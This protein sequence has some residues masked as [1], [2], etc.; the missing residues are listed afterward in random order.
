[1]T[2]TCSLYLEYCDNC[3]RGSMLYL[4]Y[5]LMDVLLR[6]TERHIDITIWKN[7]LLI[8]RKHTQPTANK[9]VD[10]LADWW[11]LGTSYALPEAHPTFQVYSVLLNPRDQRLE[12]R[13]LQELGVRQFWNLPSGKDTRA[14]WG[15][16]QF[17]MRG[18]TKTSHKLS[19][20]EGG[21]DKR[22]SFFVTGTQVILLLKCS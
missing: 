10:L 5:P 14:G 21:E 11:D 22:N 1:M 2:V 8:N 6:A 17:P 7:A 9:A 12:T 19:C 15:L 18:N 4:Y 13:Q 20:S 3:P 16:S